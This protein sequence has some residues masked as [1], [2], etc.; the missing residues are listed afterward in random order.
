MLYLTVPLNI[1]DF[2]PPVLFKIKRSM[3]SK[4]GVWKFIEDGIAQGYEAAD[5][6]KVIVSKNLHFR[7]ELALGS[8]L[9]LDAVRTI[10]GLSLANLPKGSRVLDFG[11]GGGTHYFIAN[12]LFPEKEF[13]W[14]VVETQELCIAAKVLGSENLQ[15]FSRVED[16][17]EKQYEFELAISSCAFQYTPDPLFYLNQI[18]E[19]RIKKLF[20]TRNCL[21]LSNSI[22]HYKQLSKLS[23]NGPGPLPPGFEDRI[24]SYPS[25]FLPLSVFE[26]VIQNYYEIRVKFLEDKGLYSI[27][28]ELIN[29]Y[30]HFCILK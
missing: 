21:T 23:S 1:Q 30:G 15:F 3:I 2:I 14:V 8:A 12:H 29:M 16:V 10:I 5:L 28:G 13:K 7:N 17:I 18:L 19:M 26:K 11:G 9:N 25:I 24:V 27:D 20:L 22:I 4:F 6:V